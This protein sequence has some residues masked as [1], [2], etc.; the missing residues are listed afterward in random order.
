MDVCQAPSII[1]SGTHP[2]D[3]HPTHPNEGLHVPK[4]LF[5]GALSQQGITGL[6]K[7]GG[8][9]RRAAIEATITG[10]GGTVEAF[11]FAFGGTDVI[12]VA[13]LPDNVAAGAVSTSVFTCAADRLFRAAMDAAVANPLCSSVVTSGSIFAAVIE[14]AAKLAAVIPPVATLP[15][16]PVTFPPTLPV[17]DPTAPVTLPTAPVTLPTL[18]LRLPVML[19]TMSIV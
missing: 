3:Y 14:L 4:Y 2:A 13:D 18:P 11:Y 12:V 9:G 8:T 17:T 19:P 6:R 16:L 1:S 7:E 15:T 5:Q 10:A